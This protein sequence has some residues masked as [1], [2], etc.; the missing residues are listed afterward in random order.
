MKLRGQ[1]DEAR[2]LVQQI[3]SVFETTA[4]ASYHSIAWEGRWA[5]T[6]MAKQKELAVASLVDEMRA[7]DISEADQGEFA[8]PLMGMAAADLINVFDDTLLGAVANASTPDKASLISTKLLNAVPTFAAEETMTGDELR[9]F[10]KSKMQ[11][12]PPGGRDVK[13][14]ENLATSLASMLDQSRAA[15]NYTDQTV[16]F[17]NDYESAVLPGT[18]Y[19]KLDRFR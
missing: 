2:Q 19:G 1:I 15:H 12:Y 11:E 4:A 14:L 5:G 8:K 6:D 7:L 9:A 10:C 13:P 17:L 16:S 18:Y 3:K